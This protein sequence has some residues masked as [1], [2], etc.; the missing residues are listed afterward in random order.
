MRLPSPGS[1]S[2]KGAQMAAGSKSKKRGRVRKVDF[3]ALAPIQ[4][5]AAGIDVGASAHWVAV[6]PDR[7]TEPV[8]TFSA[9]TGDLHKIADWLASCGVSTVA[10]ESTG[11]YWV[12]LYE[13]LEAR[14]FR[15]C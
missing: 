4:A 5:D 9:Y 13:I 1:S 11:V 10:M 7:D 14:G 15:V 2:S 12:P 8:R 3:D 6:P